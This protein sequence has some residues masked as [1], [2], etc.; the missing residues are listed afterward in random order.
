[1]LWRKRLLTEKQSV[2][3]FPTVAGAAQTPKCFSDLLM[4]TSKQRS[5]RLLMPTAREV[6]LF[7][8][9]GG[10]QSSSATGVLQ[11]WLDGNLIVRMATPSA[12]DAMSTPSTSDCKIVDAANRAAC[13]E[14]FNECWEAGDKEDEDGTKRGE[15]YF[16]C[17]AG[18]VSLICYHL[19]VWSSKSGKLDIKRDSP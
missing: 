16:G 15:D 6:T 9:A 5:V 10:T 18:C 2:S 1:M 7:H 19:Y 13:D 11:K 4:P 12:R 14:C 8:S 3:S 17:L